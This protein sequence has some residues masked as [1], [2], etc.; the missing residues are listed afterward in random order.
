MTKSRHQFCINLELS[1]V[2]LCKTNKNKTYDFIHFLFFCK[3]VKKDKKK[4]KTKTSMVLI[5]MNEMGVLR[6]S[7][8][9]NFHLLDFTSVDIE[10]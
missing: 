4:V 7:I 8:K 9:S 6:S 5:E 1:E 3:R 2:I 10:F